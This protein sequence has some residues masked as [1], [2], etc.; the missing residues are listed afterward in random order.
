MI[1]SLLEITWFG[2]LLPVILSRDIIDPLSFRYTLLIITMIFFFGTVVVIAYVYRLNRVPGQII[3][4]TFACQALY[5][6]TKIDLATFIY[7]QDLDDSLTY[8]YFFIIP[9]MSLIVDAWS[10]ITFFTLCPCNKEAREIKDIENGN[11]DIQ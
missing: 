9:F 7:N 8:R 10:A 5:V 11:H 2:G 4:W 6:A 1:G 3:A